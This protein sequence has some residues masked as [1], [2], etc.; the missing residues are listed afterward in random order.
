MLAHFRDELGNHWRPRA[1]RFGPREIRL[2]CMVDAETHRV[3]PR[4]H[5][6][7]VVHDLAG[8]TLRYTFARAEFQAQVPPWVLVPRI[9]VF[10]P[11][12]LVAL[13]VDDRDDQR[14][15]ACRTAARCLLRGGVSANTSPSGCTTGTP[16]VS[17]AIAP[18]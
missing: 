2:T 6:A 3:K 7:G 18:G 5:C 12:L 15:A 8:I 11:G 10:A 13:R 4:S 14:R 1:T 9:T 17:T 16:S